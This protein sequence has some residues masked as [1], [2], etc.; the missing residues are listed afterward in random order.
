QP[1]PQRSL[2]MTLGRVPARTRG[3]RGQPALGRALTMSLVATAEAGRV[4][5]GVGGGHRGR[6]AGTQVGP[7]GGG[8][9]AVR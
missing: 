4:W 3:W 7:V 1:T 9:A 8:C 6:A 2:T 5:R